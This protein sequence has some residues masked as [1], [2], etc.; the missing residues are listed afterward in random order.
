MKQ[1]LKKKTGRNL[2]AKFGEK[3][4]KSPHWLVGWFVA[5]RYEGR[6]CAAMLVEFWASSVC[7][8]SDTNPLVIKCFEMQKPTGFFVGS[9]TTSF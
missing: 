4:N 8:S 1:R 5:W 6:Y 3:P 7:S 9:H 2:W